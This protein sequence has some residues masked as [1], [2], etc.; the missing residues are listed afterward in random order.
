[1]DYPVYRGLD[2]LQPEMRTRVDDFIKNVNSRGISIVITETWRSQERQEY[3]YSLGRTR[4]GN[5]V[6]WTLQSKHLLGEAIDIAFIK[7]GKVTYDG[8]WNLIGRVGEIHGLTWGG[9][10]PSPDR[11]H[12]QFNSDWQG[13]HWGAKYEQKLLDK[14]VISY[15]KDLNE[16]PSR[17]ELYVILCRLNNL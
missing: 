3:L 12:F 11:P 8:D 13:D 4:P 17:A 16:P 6:T 1:M 14:G 7:D 9:R 10:F 5:I 15:K 2:K